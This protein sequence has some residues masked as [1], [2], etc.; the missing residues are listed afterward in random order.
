MM[1]R[2]KEVITVGGCCGGDQYSTAL[3]PCAYYIV[4]TGFNYRSGV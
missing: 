1:L 4:C 2:K 3:S